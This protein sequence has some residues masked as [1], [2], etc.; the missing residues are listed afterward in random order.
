M[1]LEDKIIVEDL[2]R[3]ISF[4]ENLYG[5]F[6]CSVDDTDE[7]KQ[8]TEYYKKGIFEIQKFLID[9][10]NTVKATGQGLILT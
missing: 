10:K 5:L 6:T 1:S 8:C 4:L 7:V 9:M 3:R 2:E